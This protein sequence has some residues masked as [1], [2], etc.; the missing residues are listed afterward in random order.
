MAPAPGRQGPPDQAAGWSLQLMLVQSLDGG[1]LGVN[2]VEDRKGHSK[3]RGQQRQEPEGAK[4]HGKDQ[5][6]EWPSVAAVGVPAGQDAGGRAGAFPSP[7]RSSPVPSQSGLLPL[8]GWASVK[9]P[10]SSPSVALSP[11]RRHAEVLSPHTGLTIIT[12]F[13]R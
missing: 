7:L 2:Q 11:C 12:S 3:Q 1:V 10:Q 9:I 8:T 4:E 13:Y 6:S 5:G